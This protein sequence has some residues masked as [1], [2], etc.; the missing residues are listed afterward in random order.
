M[1]FFILGFYGIYQKNIA[2]S[3]GHAYVFLEKESIGKLYINKILCKS[4]QKL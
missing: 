1:I 2:V 4:F 3:K